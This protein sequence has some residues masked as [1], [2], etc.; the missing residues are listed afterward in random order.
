VQDVIDN[1][2]KPPEL[3]VEGLCVR[4]AH[5]AENYAYA[6]MDLTKDRFVHVRYHL[7]CHAFELI[8]KSF[9]LST[10]EE[11]K[12]IY[13]IRHDLTKALDFALARGFTSAKQSDLR[14]FV[15]W[16]SPFHD[17]YDFRYARG[18]FQ[19]LPVAE[20]LLAIFKTVHA[21]IEPFA[22]A[23]YLSKHSPAT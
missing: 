11:R 6:A 18:G 20:D 1:Q 13:E 22:R 3:S 5:D 17:G 4:F 12:I 21:E 10:G 14:L 2:N 9:V 23:Y 8:L 7:F 16:L 15:D 19:Q